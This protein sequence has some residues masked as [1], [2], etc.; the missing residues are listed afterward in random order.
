MRLNEIHGG[1]HKTVNTM[2]TRGNWG[3]R[4]GD[5]SRSASYQKQ[6]HPRRKV[7]GGCMFC[8]GIDDDTA[9]HTRIECPTFKALKRQTSPGAYISVSLKERDADGYASAGILPFRRHAAGGIELLLAREYR[10][11]RGVK[12]NFLGGKR[13]QK[14]TDAL[15]CA[16]EKVRTETGGQLSPAT[17]EQMRDQCPLVCWSSDSLYALFLFELVGT[18]DCDVVSR[19]ARTKADGAK[20]LEW[21]TRNDLMDPR[22]VDENMHL[23][24]AKILDELRTCNVMSHLE[25]LFDVSAKSPPSGSITEDTSKEVADLLSRLTLASR[26]KAAA[27]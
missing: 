12:L 1:H 7:T 8:Q 16:I 19:C 25:D 9:D 20:S 4:R 18:A 14:G 11:Q 6:Q 10:T 23:F 21:A 22:W 24:A 5:D 3:R 17:M 27:P 13:K 2:Y 15:T 26:R